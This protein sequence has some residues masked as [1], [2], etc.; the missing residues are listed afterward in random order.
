MSD[1]TEAPALVGHLESALVGYAHIFGHVKLREM[2]STDPQ[3]IA[4]ESRRELGMLGTWLGIRPQ[5]DN[6]RARPHRIHRSFTTDIGLTA[7][8]NL[9]EW[10]V[11]E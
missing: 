9:T 2:W 8:L 4:I 5:L 3:G 7:A 10:L 11:D 6:A 1:N